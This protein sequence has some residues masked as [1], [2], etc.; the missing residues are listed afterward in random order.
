MPPY[1]KTIVIIDMKQPDQTLYNN[2]FYC[3]YNDECW[4][5]LSK[6]IIE[7]MADSYANQFPKFCRNQV[8]FEEL[9]RK[10]YAPIRKGILA[11]LF[12]GPV[13]VLVDKEAF[14]DAFNQRW[15]DEVRDYNHI[16]NLK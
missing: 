16:N 5:R 3:H 4:I 6:C 13:R 8:E 12:N 14:T 11:K 2:P 1:K 10:S 7:A 9:D 15:R